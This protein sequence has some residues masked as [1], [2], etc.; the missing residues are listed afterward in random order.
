MSSAFLLEHNKIM[1]NVRLHIKKLLEYGETQS[2]IAR[3]IGISQPTVAKIASG[4]THASAGTAIKLSKAY[5]IDLDE[6]LDGT[7]VSAPVFGIGIDD[8]TN[9]PVSRRRFPVISNVNGGHG[10]GSCWESHS[11]EYTTGPEDLTD[12]SAFAM[13]VKGDSMAPKYTDGMLVY[14]SPGTPP[15]NGDFVAVQLR[16]DERIVK[17]YQ[18]AG[19][20]VILESINPAYPPILMK[21]YEIVCIA[22]VTHSKEK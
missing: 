8:I 7:T 13:R 10:S 3:K 19:D 1:E 14:C 18:E 5:N 12:P 9:S 16:D 20:T 6:L 15:Q 4:D 21:K 22:K 2:A 11:N 17:R